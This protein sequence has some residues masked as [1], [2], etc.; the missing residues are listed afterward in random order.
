MIEGPIDSLIDLPNR[1]PLVI[2]KALTQTIRDAQKA[3]LDNL[4]RELTI[5]GDWPSPS[6]HYGIHATFA[7]P[8]SLSA[9]LDTA[10]WWLAQTETGETHTPI[11]GHEIA[12]PSYGVQPDPKQ[13]VPSSLFPRNLGNQ[14]VFI[15][16]KDGRQFIF[17]RTGPGPRDMKLAYVLETKVSR[18]RHEVVTRPAVETIQKNLGPNISDQMNQELAK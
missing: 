6:N 15:R 3:V 11:A 2:A 16:A 7:T 10:A 5:R 14:A 9:Q 8:D 17:I 18:P 13:L 12:V 4:P 1:L